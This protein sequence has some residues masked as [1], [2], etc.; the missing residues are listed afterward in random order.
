MHAD[1]TD[2][3]IQEAYEDVRS[4]KSDTTWLLL[5]YEDDSP[6][7]LQVTQTGSGGIGEVVELLDD[8]KASFAYV[9][10][11]YSNDAES[12]REKF[13]LVTWIGKGIKVM[14]RARTSTQLADVKK[15]LRQFS[16]EVT[17]DDKGEL[18]EDLIVTKL[19][20]A[21]GAYYGPGK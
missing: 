11:V 10:V 6:T 17:V 13:I 8:N 2:S 18:R 19:R 5:D 20:T 15:I 9:R 21:G 14:R 12:K 16:T 1:L 4:D 7:K 3:K